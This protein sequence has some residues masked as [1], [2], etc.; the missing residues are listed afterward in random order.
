MLGERGS[1]A[2]LVPQL[3]ICCSYSLICSVPREP[4]LTTL[5]PPTAFLA[6]QLQGGCRFL[7]CQHLHPRRVDRR[8]AP[9][10][11]RGVGNP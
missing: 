11:P 2:W 1:V 8:T 4:S 7:S 6:R 10:E 9:W 3:F 5:P